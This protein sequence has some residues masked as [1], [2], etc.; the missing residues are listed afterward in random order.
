MKINHKILCIP[1]HI[2]TAWEHIASVKTEKIGEELL[3]YIVLRTGSL[4]TIPGLDRGVIDAIFS[5]HSKHLDSSSSSI[6]QALLPEQKKDFS[7]LLNTTTPLTFAEFRGLT[8]ALQHDFEYSKIPN[9]PKEILDKISLLTLSMEIKDIHILPKEEPHCNC[10]HCQIV[11]SMKSDIEKR[12]VT[13]ED[14]WDEDVSDAD[15]HFKS[16]IIYPEKNKTYKII[17]PD[18]RHESYLV[19][20]GSPVSCSC[21]S[22][23]CEHIKAVLNS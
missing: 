2:S 3:L 4:V 20:L 12:H 22:S 19:H 17:H 21:G 18:Q 5:A 9:F 6:T 11:R 7:S 16:W 13:I 8:S 23:Q 14:C 15:L 1:P 10:P